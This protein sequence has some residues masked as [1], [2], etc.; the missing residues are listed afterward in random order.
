MTD[1]LYLI[2][3]SVVTISLE[4]EEEDLTM[5]M[6]MEIKGEVESVMGEAVIYVVRRGMQKVIPVLTIRIET[7][8]TVLI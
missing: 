5:R 7:N 4:V 6:K 1:R 8:D 2:L 3:G